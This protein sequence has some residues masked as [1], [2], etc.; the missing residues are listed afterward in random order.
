M[1]SSEFDQRFEA[2]HSLLDALDLTTARSPRQEQK[3]VTVNPHQPA[4]AIPSS[5]IRFQKPLL[6]A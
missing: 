3:R 1:Q 4:W 5:C 6:R 2:G